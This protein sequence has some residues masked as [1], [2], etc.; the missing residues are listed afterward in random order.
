MSITRRKLIQQFLIMSGGVLVLPSCMQSESKSSVLL[1]NVKISGDDE[2]L[3]TELGETILPATDSPGAKDVYAHLYT[4]RMLDDCSPKEDQEK[5]TRGLKAFS[6]FSE[7]RL[8]TGFAA[9]T[10]DQRRQLL[11]AVE[12]KK[13]IPEDVQAFY[14]GYK[15]ATITAFVNSRYFL[16]NVQKYELV[17]GRFNGCAPVKASAKKQA[18]A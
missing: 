6:R 4:L 13:D 9:A 15:R 3:L 2:K 8:K 17:P 10:P 11:T 14:E 1:K 7:D 5:F 12:G 16:T 18:A